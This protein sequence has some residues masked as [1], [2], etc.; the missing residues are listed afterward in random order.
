MIKSIVY[1]YHWTPK[2]ISNMFVDDYDFKGLIYWYDEL[3][4]I[5]KQMKKNK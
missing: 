4:R 5:D 2:V 3:I 1:E